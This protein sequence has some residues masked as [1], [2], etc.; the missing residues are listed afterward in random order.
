[1]YCTFFLHLVPLVKPY[2]YPATKSQ[3]EKA[4][5]RTNQRYLPGDKRPVSNSVT[6]TL[7]TVPCN[8]PIQSIRESAV[9]R[10]AT[11]FAIRRNH[12]IETANCHTTHCVGVQPQCR[13]TASRL[14]L[15]LPQPPHPTAHL[16]PKQPKAAP[17]NGRGMAPDEA[18]LAPAPVVRRYGRTSP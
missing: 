13:M 10:S 18:V 5:S 2:M 11:L 6:S 3:M 14:L 7:L 4:S 15:L 12:I 8:H 1:M 17:D 9:R 16:T